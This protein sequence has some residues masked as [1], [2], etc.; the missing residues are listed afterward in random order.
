MLKDHPAAPAAARPGSALLVLGMHRSGTSAVAGLLDSLGVRVPGELLP[1]DAAS[2]PKGFWEHAGIVSLHERVLAALGSGWEDARNLPDEWWSRLELEPLR[3]ELTHILLTEFA[4]VNP[5][6]VKDPRLCRLLPLWR[7]VLAAQRLPAHALLVVRDPRE[8][9]RSLRQ[10]DGMAEDMAHLLWLQHV[11][12][13]ERWTRDLPRSVIAFDELLGNWEATLDRAMGE[14][15]LALPSRTDA[16]R[17]A[18]AAFLAPEL[19]HHAGGD[20]PASGGIQ[21]LALACYEACLGAMPAGAMQA[22][23]EPIATE[24]RAVARCG[25]PWLSNLIE[26]QRAHSHDVRVLMGEIARIKGTVSWRITAP[27]RGVWNLVRPRSK[28]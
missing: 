20:I 8:V 3:R 10:R 11:T 4:G 16:A 22:A 24:T 2:N 18:A 14:L 26:E 7:P 1:A 23:L 21:E 15:G 19:R 5:W 17:R 12:E 9:A 13:S 27:L 25:L 6:V 28:G